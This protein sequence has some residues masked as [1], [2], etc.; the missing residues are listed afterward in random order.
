VSAALALL[1]ARKG[2]RPLVL[3]CDGRPTVG[4][5][6]GG[7]PEGSSATA[8]GQGV[9][10]LTVNQQETLVD[11]LGEMLGAR[12]L[13]EM[14]LANRVVRTFTTAAPSVME[15][16]LL[17][18]VDRARGEAEPGGP[19][20][21]V[22]VDLPASGH[23]LALLSTPRAV[24]RLVRV[25]PLFRRAQDLLRM[26]HDSR[27]TALVAV[28]LAE[29]LPVNE[30]L[31]LCQKARG[32]NIPVGVVVVNA[33]PHAPLQAQDAEVLGELQAGAPDPVKGWARDALAGSARGERAWA[34]IARLEEAAPGRV[35]QVPFA[36]HSGAELAGHISR[37]LER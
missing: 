23:A 24:M 27:N 1:A 13:V 7:P 5:L 31:E 18:R 17:H 15:L 6:L 14:F 32:L 10:A 3:T 2:K 16:T 33:V 11:L 29:E 35:T 4:R 20:S 36:T 19:F 9:Y 28:T 22:I 12:R 37:A 8:V 34:M 25:G 30:T 26:V 21:P